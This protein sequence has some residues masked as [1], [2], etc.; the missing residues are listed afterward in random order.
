MAVNKKILVTIGTRP[1]A[2]K[3][4]PV[5]H[6]LRES[7][8]ADVVVVSTSQHDDLL[9]PCLEFFE[10]EPDVDLALMKPDQSLADLTGRMIIALNAAFAEHEPDHVMA[11]GDTTTAFV[12][13]LASFYRKLPFAHVEAG[14]RT[15]NKYAPFPEEINRVLVTR[16]ADVHF[17]PTR[18]ARDALLAEGVPPGSVHVTGNTVIDA[19]QW[20]A[21]RV[22][23]KPVAATEGRKLI[24]V[25]AHRRESFGEG[26]AGI[27]AALRRLADREDVEILYPVHPNPN[28]AAP[29]R[30]ALAGH[31]RIRLSP[32]L[33]Y[34]DFVAAMQAC[35]VILTDSGGVQEEAPSLAK[36]VL[37]LRDETERTEGIEAGTARLVGTDPDTIVAHTAAL[38]DDPEIYAQ[39]AHAS[40]PYGDGRAAQRIAA[41]LQEVL[42]PR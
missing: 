33:D 28:V 19:L 8:I 40:N 31:A 5:V 41:V 10:I 38:L 34:P 42:N 7:R 23:T 22:G 37:V 2:I 17:A 13:A 24:L 12:S 4:A 27:C 32:P 15:G 1:D 30:E 16:L 20:S 21:L 6:E 9:G 18:H 14:L 29:V 36:P 11:Q 26:L 35:D 3:L 39:M 25:T